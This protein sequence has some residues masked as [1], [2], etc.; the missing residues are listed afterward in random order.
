MRVVFAQMY[1]GRDFLCPLCIYWNLNG[2]GRN[3]SHD[4]EVKI[5]FNILQQKNFQTKL[6]KINFITDDWFVKGFSEAADYFQQSLQ[7]EVKLRRIVAGKIF[8]LGQN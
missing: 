1:K 3:F 7:K 8:N 5:A 6:P 2:S 4:F